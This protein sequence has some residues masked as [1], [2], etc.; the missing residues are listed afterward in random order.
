MIVATPLFEAME[1]YRINSQALSTGFDKEDRMTVAFW[2]L[3]SCG[4][5]IYYAG[6][7]IHLIIERTLLSKVKVRGFRIEGT[8]KGAQTSLSVKEVAYVMA[9][10]RPKWEENMYRDSG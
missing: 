10:S 5:G 9:G 7:S 2:S 8:D 1:K 3:P 6:V 4:H